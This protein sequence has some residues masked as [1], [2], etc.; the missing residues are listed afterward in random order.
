MK[1]DDF[2]LNTP[3]KL[4]IFGA[5]K[6][7]KSTFAKYLSENKYEDSRTTIKDKNNGNKV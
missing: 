6:S 3:K 1:V 5:N 2:Q 4:I 7:G